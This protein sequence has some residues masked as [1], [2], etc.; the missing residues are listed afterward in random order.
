MPFRV[1]VLYSGAK[2]AKSRL[3][4]SGVTQNGI[5]IQ[6]R[7]ILPWL[8]IHAIVEAFVGF[9]GTGSSHTRQSI[10]ESSLTADASSP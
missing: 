9:R 10:G 6:C 4:E 3:E 2:N 5:N 8:P 1:N 7:S